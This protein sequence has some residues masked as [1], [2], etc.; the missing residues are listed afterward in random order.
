[1]QIIGFNFE[2][3]S[4][5]REIPKEVKD[6]LEINSNINIKDI[7]QEKVEIVKDKLPLK[8][9]FEFLITYNPQVAK[10]LFQGFAILLFDKEKAKEIL[11]KWKNKKIEDD[12]RIPLF[13]FILTKC[14][15]RALQLEEELNLPLH[16]PLPKIQANQNNKSYTG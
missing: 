14:N 2:K 15:I 11:K 5:E 9:S 4:A 7:I 10:I 8:F 16:I 1:M 12:I 6:K 13:N 3:I